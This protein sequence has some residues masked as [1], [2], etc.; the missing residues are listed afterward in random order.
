VTDVPLCR[1]CGDPIGLRGRGGPRVWCSKKCQ[2]TY[3]NRKSAESGYR[4]PGRTRKRDLVNAAKSKPCFDCGGS[5][6]PFVMD[7]DHRDSNEKHASLKGRF[8]THIQSL[9]FEEMVAEI[10]KCDPVCANCHRIRTHKQ[11]W[12]GAV[13][14]GGG[15]VRRWKKRKKATRSTQLRLTV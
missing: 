2:W 7:L 6:P 8:R 13:K 12:S 9:P 4:G 11:F 1:G 14:L 15:K 10:E 3:K 5:F